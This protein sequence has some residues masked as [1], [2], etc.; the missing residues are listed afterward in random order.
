MDKKKSVEKEIKSIGKWLNKIFLI[1]VM[2]KNL[3]ISSCNIK[4]LFKNVNSCIS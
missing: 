3:I 2:K 4:L 1:V